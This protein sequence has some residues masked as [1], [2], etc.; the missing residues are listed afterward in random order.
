MNLQKEVKPQNKESVEILVQGDEKNS[1][2]DPKAVM[3][4]REVDPEAGREAGREA[5]SRNLN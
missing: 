4:D 1:T 2:P 5:G 3:Q